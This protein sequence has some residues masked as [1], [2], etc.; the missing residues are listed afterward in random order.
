M[1]L[2]ILILI[3]AIL[4]TSCSEFAEKDQTKFKKE[5][6][7]NGDTS[8]FYKL[9]QKKARLLSLDS[10]QN[11][12]DSLE[13]RIWTNSSEPV[14][15]NLI[16]IKKANSIWTA[17]NYIMSDWER[18]NTNDSIKIMRIKKLDPIDNT[19]TV[20]IIKIKNLKP[21]GSWDKFL[22]KLFALK[23]MTLPNMN[24]IPGLVDTWSDEFTYS[25][26]LAT[27]NEYRFYNYHCPHNFQDKFWQA[28][29]MV[30]IKK[31]IREELH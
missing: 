5:I 23:I 8:I 31:L 4:L 16:V 27:K 3:L 28:K 6:P 2:N 18:P 25:I 17:T 1:K 29:N 10:L 14:Y 26:E 15:S 9:I 12:Y 30:E 24:D 11:G 22:S 21:I 13:I 7:K 20:E 19:D